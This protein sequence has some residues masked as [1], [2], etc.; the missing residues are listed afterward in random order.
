MQQAQIL[1]K[2]TRS[3]KALCVDSFIGET[4]RL[5]SELPRH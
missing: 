5:P 1:P 3:E 4:H 2:P